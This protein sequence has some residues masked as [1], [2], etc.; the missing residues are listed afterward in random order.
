MAEPPTVEKIKSDYQ[1]D[2]I[3][4]RQYHKA[5]W[6]KSRETFEERVLGSSAGIGRVKATVGQ[7]WDDLKQRYQEIQDSERGAATQQRL[8]EEMKKTG[9]MPEAIFQ[10]P[11]DFGQRVLKDVGAVWD[12]I[13]RPAQLSGIGWKHTAAAVGA[14]DWLAK[15]IGFL[16]ENAASTVMTAK[17]LANAQAMLGTAAKGAARGVANLANKAITPAVGT[18]E[19]T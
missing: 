16:G 15:L 2:E 1:N 18:A 5:M 10:T 7:M 8:T 9:K 4:A 3:N 17:P 14:P 19:E 13:N 12:S 11:E 6:Q